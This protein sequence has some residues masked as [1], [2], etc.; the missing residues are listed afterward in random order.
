MRDCAYKK[1]RLS[2]QILRR[3]KNQGLGRCSCDFV[4]GVIERLGITVRVFGHYV[5]A[6]C[7]IV[8]L[9]EILMAQLVDD[10]SAFGRHRETLADYDS[11]PSRVAFDAEFLDLFVIEGNGKFSGGYFETWQ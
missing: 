3:T 10:D 11:P 5:D 2:L 7:S 4:T 6:T 8:P 1:F 9:V